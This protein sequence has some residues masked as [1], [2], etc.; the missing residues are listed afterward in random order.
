MGSDLKGIKTIRDFDLKDK[1]VFLRLDLNVPLENGKITDETRITASLPTIKY[2]LE[3]GAKL[4]MASH[5]GRPKAAGDKKYS[6]EPVADRLGEL[7][8]REVILIEE[9]KSDA[10]KAL[11]K[12]AAKNQIVLLEN[13][14]YEPGETENS[15]EFAQ[16]MASYTD[17]YINDAFGASHRAHASID[18]LPRLLKN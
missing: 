14:R 8:D 17:I 1:I 4:V 16:A 11:T 12:G 18:A 13:L 10:V 9:P 2:A 7:L 15:E 3:K 6:M 5:L